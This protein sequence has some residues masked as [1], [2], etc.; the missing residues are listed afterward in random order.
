MYGIIY[1]SLGTISA[2]AH[3]YSCGFEH[4]EVM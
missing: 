4:W 2:V 1:R 3:W